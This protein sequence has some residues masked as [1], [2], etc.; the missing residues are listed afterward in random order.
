MIE[1]YHTPFPDPDPS[2]PDFNLRMFGYPD[3]NEWFD[4]DQYNRP[5][6]AFI[7]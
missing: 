6:N 1:Q 7:E 5:N 3:F 4:N 2:Q